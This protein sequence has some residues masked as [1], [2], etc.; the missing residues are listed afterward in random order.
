MADPKIRYDILANAEGEEDVAR[1]ARELQKLDDAIDP[2]A[3]QRAAALA[4]ELRKLG[5]QQEAINTFTVLKRETGNARTAL[6]QAQAAAQ[7]FGQEMAATASPTRAQV[8]QFEK[9]KDAVQA[10]KL[11]LQAKTRALDAARGELT[12]LGIATTALTGKELALRDSIKATRAEISQLGQQGQ[13]VQ[14]FQELSQA[15][16]TAAKRLQQAD[17]ALRQYRQGLNASDEPT[18]LQARQ[19]ARLAEAARTAQ[20]AFQ[21]SA[22]AQAQASTAL[23]AAG[24]DTERLANG[25][26][27]LPPALTATASA[28][29]QVAAGYTQA[30]AAAAASAAQQR[31]A[32][33]EVKAGL[34]GIASQ[35][36]S[37]RNIGVGAVLGSQT[38][39]L[40]RGVAETADAF[41]NLS[42]RMK[43]VTG[44]GPALQAALKGVEQIAL[45][46]GSSLESTG[47][48][49]TRIATAGK[50]I[51]LG[52]AD[53]LKLTESINQAVQ[54][55][56]A[57]ATA[58][59]AALTQLIQGL[60]SGVLRGEEFNS[61]VE[62]APRLAQALA[63]GLGVARGELRGLANDG[64]LSAESVIT[65]LQS[66]SAVLQKEFGT[67]PA[68]VGRSLQNLSTQWSVFVAGLDSASGATS[69]VAAGIN[70]IANNLETLAGVASRAGAVLLAAVAIQEVAAL[71]A[72][73]VQAGGTA[74]A[75]ALLGTSIDK[76]PKA[77]N[78]AIAVTGLELGYQIGDFLRE[79][80]ELARKLGVGVTEFFVGLVNDLQFVKEA[81]AAIFT[82]DTIGQAFDRF[83]ARAEQQ[84][85]IFAELYRD[86]EQ[87]PEVVR[88]AAASAEAAL[89]DMGTGAGQAGAAVATAGAAGAAGVASVGKA[90]QS[91]EGAITALAAA[92]NVKLPAVAKTIE[93]QARAMAELAVKSR[94]VSDRIGT[95]LPAAIAKL[96]G[97]ELAQFRNA[98][99]AALGAGA[100]Q[101]GLLNRLLLET[102]KRAA[103]ALG[104]DLAKA[105][106]TLSAEFA[107][108]QDNLGLLVRSTGAL[109][110]AGLDAGA[111]VA[112]ALSKMAEQA[113]NQAE[114]DALRLRIEALGKAGQL[115]KTQVGDLLDTVKNKADEAARSVDKVAQ[116]YKFFGLTTKAELA[117]VAAESAKNWELIRNDATASLAQKQTAFKRYADEAMAANGGVVTSTIR[118]EAQ[119]LK[120][121]L[122]ADATGKVIVQ[123]MADASAAVQTTTQRLN[124]M[125]EEIDANGQRINAMVASLSG[126][127]VAG[128]R[129]PGS[130]GAAD[131]QGSLPKI[132]SAGD[133]IRATPGGGITRTGTGQFQPP[134]SSGRWIFDVEKWNRSGQPVQSDM[135]AFWRLNPDAA[136]AEAALVAD[137]ARRRREQ[138]A[139]EAAMYPQGGAAQRAQAAA[140][141]SAQGAA[142]ITMV[143]NIGGKQ[144]SISATSQSAAD[145][146]IAALEAA[147][148]AGGGS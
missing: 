31:G 98:F 63:D 6:D 128:V 58:S 60:Q 20:L 102:G 22:Q 56:G 117:K 62:Q 78:I 120:L 39:Q 109:R 53:A 40:L 116:A 76:I 48:L 13:A 30:G 82:D 33:A 35:L 94:E 37:L 103:Q 110:R 32:N 141:A 86:A 54:I 17:E 101:A 52:Q 29:R 100:E 69:T 107:A 147:Y 87:S 11:E 95:E 146:T 12:D 79:N 127:S 41:N 74:G 112:A 67:L 80:S 23:R 42:A 34:D 84:R 136:A 10:S 134:D 135:S 104:V 1:L 47:T 143:V 113:G 45:S 133:L 55:S 93:Q 90:A 122:Q 77:I 71:R 3:A 96:S 43:L 27:R 131:A 114:F 24:V 140:S 83:K 91:A 66:Q 26:Q 57:S 59:D 125:G 144:Y 4:T 126:G 51:G 15:T 106:N 138:Q 137:P 89:K 46:T 124:E 9:L 8:G 14:R 139:S 16:D 61:V 132:D 73:A 50:D 118:A 92:A 70:G 5:Q 129:S 145:Q 68:T 72:L 64:K 148:L 111:V 99:V 81:A 119:S 85:A 142:N 28:A 123:S 121:G 7:K 49:F 88:A 19:L 2:A 38:V 44:E 115:S 25:Q 18:A 97:P 21:S 105:T 108:A 65:A 130:P 36:G 75:M